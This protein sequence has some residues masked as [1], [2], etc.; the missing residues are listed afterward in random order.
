[1]LKIS[2]L[3]AF[4]LLATD[5]RVTQA[6]Y[7]SCCCPASPQIFEVHT[8]SQYFA[9][10]IILFYF[11]RSQNTPDDFGSRSPAG[12]RSGSSSQHHTPPPSSSE[13]STSQLPSALPISDFTSSGELT[14]HGH[15]VTP[16]D[17]LTQSDG[18]EQSKGSRSRSGNRHRSHDHKH[19]SR[20]GSTGRKHPRDPTG[21]SAKLKIKEK[22]DRNSS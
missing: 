14:G 20:S 22:T 16:H 19:K 1:M 3:T 2:K 10:V 9:R 8:A 4:H 13:S 7:S 5:I 15:S 18:A 12:R 6:E 21:G 17:N 11:S